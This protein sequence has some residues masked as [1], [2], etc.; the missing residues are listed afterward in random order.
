MSSNH[1]NTISNRRYTSSFISCVFSVSCLFHPI[2][3]FPKKKHTPLWVALLL[4]LAK[5]TP[6]KTPRDLPVGW[7]PTA[8]AAKNGNLC[9]TGWFDVI[10]LIWLG[11]KRYQKWWELHK[12]IGIH[13]PQQ[14]IFVM[15]CLIFGNIVIESNQPNDVSFP[16]N[17]IK[18]TK[19]ISHK[20]MCR[21][22]M[23]PQAQLYE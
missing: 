2:R 6:W 14:T 4:H 19:N 11:Q 15:F 16:G 22:M 17:C 3:L 1:L 12:N 10:C 21:K 5:S 18:P 8:V 9:F 7:S 13:F 23:G 20:N